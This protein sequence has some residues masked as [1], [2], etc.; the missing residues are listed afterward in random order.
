M[1]SSHKFAI[2]VRFDLK[3]V[4]VIYHPCFKPL[5]GDEKMNCICW[6]EKCNV[7]EKKEN[8]KNGYE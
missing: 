2:S 6:F 4:G 3:S 1:T 8:K 7:F 5:E